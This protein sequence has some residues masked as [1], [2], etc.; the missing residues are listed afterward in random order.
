MFGYDND[1]E[2][3]NTTIISLSI[4][5]VHQMYSFLLMLLANSIQDHI[6][7]VGTGYMQN[8]FMTMEVFCSQMM[9]LL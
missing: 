2:D 7:W 6:Q 4:N 5:A 3:P 1:N 9:V 8:F